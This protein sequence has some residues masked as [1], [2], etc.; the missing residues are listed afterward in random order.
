[1]PMILFHAFIHL[2]LEPSIKPQHLRSSKT[3][4]KCSCQLKLY[5]W[6]LKVGIWDVPTTFPLSLSLSLTHTHTHWILHKV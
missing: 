1:M 5:K 4:S 2:L 6:F 3:F